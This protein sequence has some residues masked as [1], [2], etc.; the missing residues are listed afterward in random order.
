VSRRSPSPTSRPTGTGRRSTWRRCRSACSTP[1]DS[2]LTPRSSRSERRPSSRPRNAGSASAPPSPA[3]RGTPH[4]RPAGTRSAKR[5]ATR[6]TKR[7]ASSSGSAT[8]AGTRRGS[9]GSD[10]DDEP[11]AP[12]LPD[13]LLFRGHRPGIDDLQI[14]DVLETAF[15]AWEGRE[16]NVFEDWR[17]RFLDREEVRPELQVLVADGERIV[18][19]SINYD[20]ADDVEGWVEQLAVH[21]TYQ[22]RGI[23]RALLEESFRRFRAMG[24]RACGLSTDSRTGAL[25]L[26]E[27]VGMR[28]RKSYSR[29]NKRL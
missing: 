22:G 17:A 27:H 6:S 11:T 21:P 23:G 25:G 7:R 16:P 4:A 12:T 19:V 13:G 15:S 29:W 8:S 2:S 3:G 20:Y 9:S 1:T 26:Y 10:L 28:V 24:R 18:G 14:F 5:S